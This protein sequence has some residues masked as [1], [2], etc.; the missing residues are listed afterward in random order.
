[1][2]E[3]H[4]ITGNRG[5]F[6]Q[7]VKMIA[8]GEAV[9]FVGAGASAGLYPLWPQLIERLADVVVAA[10]AEPALKSAWCRMDALQAAL[11]IRKRLSE[12][13]F[14]EHIREIFGPT[15]GADGQPFTPT[16][17]ALARLGFRAFV[18][19]NYDPALIYACQAHCPGLAVSPFDWRQD[20]VALWLQGNLTADNELPI[21][22]AHGRYDA[23]DSLVL[24]AEDYR[25]TY[26]NDRYRLL[27]EHLW[28][29]ERLVV[30]GF[31]FRDPWLR[32]IAEQ[33][34]WRV[35]AHE[36]SGPRH[37]A[38]LGLPQ[39][40]LAAIEAY[41]EEFEDGYRL[42]AL[43]YPVA[44]VPG[45]DGKERDDHTALGLLL[46]ELVTASS[47]ARMSTAP[48]PPTVSSGQRAETTDDHTDLLLAGRRRE[49][50][51]RQRTRSWPEAE[52][53]DSAGDLVIPV[54]FSAEW[55]DGTLECIR[56]QQRQWQSL[57][58]LSLRPEKVFRS[59]SYTSQELGDSELRL[60]DPL[61]SSVLPPSAAIGETE[62][63]RVFTFG[64]FYL[65]MAAFHWVEVAGCSGARPFAFDWH[66]YPI[67]L[68]VLED[69][70]EL[71][72]RSI[73]DQPHI[74][75]LTDSPAVDVVLD[76]EFPATARMVVPGT[77]EVLVLPSTAPAS[78]APREVMYVGGSS[79]E[80]VAATLRDVCKERFQL[81]DLKAVAAAVRDKPESC[82]LTFHPYELLLSE[83]L[84]GFRVQDARYDSVF[85]FAADCYWQ[86]DKWREKRLNLL[87]RL[88]SDAMDD[89]SGWKATDV[90]AVCLRNEGLA[91]HL[92]SLRHPGI[93]G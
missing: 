86:A 3:W 90:L 45:S 71:L 32:I 15:K 84:G 61:W 67:S 13:I 64:T 10:G 4:D 23:K 73:D 26:G 20:Q 29:R 79:S 18:T 8:T 49:L 14:A 6:D 63:I 81:S 56:G 59:L 16:H 76:E 60:V 36:L 27:F 55:L 58:Q 91:A 48:D 42:R 50:A 9:A 72:H 77:R 69:A 31:G 38:L 80:V 85:L 24:D 2:M 44:R 93:L 11:Q 30:V 88:L 82:I 37:F 5:V 78:E 34:L 51:D 33:A 75:L 83:S 12:G 46:D 17:A 54:G 39:A 70:R 22:H 1:M 74:I 43:F 35:D 68:L 7:L 52:S 28:I 21:L 53:A 89:V 19:T 41:R 87:L 47:A 40:D 25:R 65:T 92:C 57:R 66:L 62:R